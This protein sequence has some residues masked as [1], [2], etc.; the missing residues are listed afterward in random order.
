M[1]NQIEHYGDRPLD[2]E[3]LLEEMKQVWGTRFEVLT[4][5]ER[6]WMIHRISE[7]L[8]EFFCNDSD[9]DSVRES[10]SKACGRIW[11]NEL[12]VRDQLGLIE[13]LVNQM[14][15]FSR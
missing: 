2:D 15:T 4:N 13:A 9:D 10:V 7:N 14:K 3:G 1:T 11:D 5:V 6:S 8:C 12:S